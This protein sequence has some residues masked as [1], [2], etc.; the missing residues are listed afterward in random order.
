M[1]SFWRWLWGLSW[2]EM[3]AAERTRQRRHDVA[4]VRGIDNYLREA[5]NVR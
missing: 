3:Q 1:R 5:R 2:A 4:L